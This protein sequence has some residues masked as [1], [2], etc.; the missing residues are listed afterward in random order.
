MA[1]RG[2]YW[3]EQL[4]VCGGGEEARR[5]GSEQTGEDRVDVV[6]AASFVVHAFEG[7]V[8][9]RG[10]GDVRGRCGTGRWCLPLVRR[11]LTRTELESPL[12]EEGAGFGVERENNAPSFGAN[13]VVGTA[14]GQ[15]GGVTVLDRSPQGTG[16]CYG[17]DRRVHS[18]DTALKQ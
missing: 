7:E 6:L 12:A 18:G 8:N 13:V 15:A 14:D 4:I 1:G 16:R 11:L 3:I 5:T 17:R 9:G 10:V 2:Q